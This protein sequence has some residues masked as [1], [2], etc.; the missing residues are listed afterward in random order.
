M[1]GGGDGG[2][3]GGGRTGER[4][5]VRLLGVRA[6]PIGVDEVL[7][8]VRDP[9]AGGTAVFVGTV[10]REDGGKEVDELGYS[11]HP[12]VEE[13]LAQVAQR[14]AQRHPVVALAALHRTGDLAVGDVAV[15]VAAA[16]GHRGEAFDACR[17][18]VEDLK[19]Q[20]PLWKHQRFADGSDEWVGSA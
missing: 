6:T 10:R 19:H 18:L 20:V 9:A 5:P 3:D 14:V 15:V 8:A 1:S 16:A 4:G 7:A 17:E 11:A 13:V 2:G 12:R